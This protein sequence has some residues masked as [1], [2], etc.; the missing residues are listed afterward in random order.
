MI[1]GVGFYSYTLGNL[2]QIIQRKDEEQLEIQT[3]IDVLKT[4]QM[5]TNISNQLSI[6]IIRNLKNL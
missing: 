1:L 5:R 6:R 3:K 2:T 4:F